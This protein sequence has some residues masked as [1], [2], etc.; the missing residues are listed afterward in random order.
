MAGVVTT[1][2]HPKFCPFGVNLLESNWR[3]ILL[4][5]GNERNGCIFKMHKKSDFHTDVGNY[6]PLV[7]PI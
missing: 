7:P 5:S 2:V 6:E 3:V 1:S 4:V